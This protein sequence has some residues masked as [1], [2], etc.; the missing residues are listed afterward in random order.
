MPRSL[1]ARLAV[2]YVALIVS[3][4][5]LLTVALIAVMQ[6][7]YLQTVRRELATE[8]RIAAELVDP[9]LDG[10]PA[11]LD[12]LAKRIGRDT[13]TRLTIIR[14]D[15]VVLGDSDQSPALMDNHAD[16]P[17]VAQALATGAGE[18]TR[19]SAT[20]HEDMVYAAVALR[21][22]GAPAGVVRVAIPLS[23]ADAARA[24]IAAV[25]APAGVLIS[26]LAVGLAIFI[27]RRTTNSLAHLRRV[28]IRLAAGDLN[29]RAREDLPGEVSQLAVTM[30]QMAVQLSSTIRTLNEKQAR[31]DAI[32]TRMA[33]GLL[34]VD[35]GDAVTQIN[36]EA[37]RILNVEAAQALGRTFTQ[38]TRDHEMAACLR[39]ARE[40]GQE[41]SRVIEQS[42]SRRLLRMIATPQPGDTGAGACLVLLQ[43]LTA[44]RRLETSR[45]DFVSNISHELRTPLAALQA[46]A[47]TLAGGALDD[48]PAA[49]RFVERIADEVRQLTALVNDLLD[50]SSI[51]SG[52]APIRRTP[53]DL[54]AVVRRAAERLQ[55]QAQRAGV[56][57][58]AGDAARVIV[59]ADGERIEQVLLNLIHNAIKFTPAGGTIE[60]RVSAHGDHVTVSVRDTGVGI[61]AQDLPRVFERFY[62]ADKSRAGGG[63]G[64]GLA[65]A[66]HIVELHGGAIWAESA[67]GKGTTLL[68][69]LPLE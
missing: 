60:C 37:R 30:N 56:D 16:R 24:Q 42:G 22:G 40:S 6:A 31:L 7:Y 43:D 32:L 28:A 23:R 53:L 36:D 52:R 58:R 49:R 48:P 19:Y 65:I 1:S 47:D 35:G 38:V 51:E 11:A 17:E 69:T 33:D 29:A 54:G 4:L 34:I 44:V 15:G 46:L 62:K 18:A 10:D 68:F 64:L 67:E 39:A 13:A 12:A 66:K 25:M 59:K 57:L 14:R 27:A 55:P 61:S 50:L 2:A 21:R 41:Q 45:R 20:L 8:G 63:T 3:A 5:A 26:L 9:L